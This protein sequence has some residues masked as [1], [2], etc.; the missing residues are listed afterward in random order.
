MSRWPHM[1]VAAAILAAGAMVALAILQ[2]PLVAPYRFVA[3][4]GTIYRVNI[5]TGEGLSCE[6]QDDFERE[7]RQ[8][9]C[10]LVLSSKV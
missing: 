9:T 10:I 5:V 2:A 1:V 3:K 6:V 4:D 7:A 8:R